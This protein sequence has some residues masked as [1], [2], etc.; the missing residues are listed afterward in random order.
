MREFTENAQFSREMRDGRN[1]YCLLSPFHAGPARVE[2]RCPA[3]G[4]IYAELTLCC[5]LEYV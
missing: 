5:T 3:Y 2:L 1:A 4:T